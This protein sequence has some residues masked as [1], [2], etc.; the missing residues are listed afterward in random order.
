MSEPEKIAINGA[1]YRLS[2]LSEEARR[3]FEM[4]RV[5]DGKLAELQRDVTIHQAARTAYVEALLKTLPAKP[6][7]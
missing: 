7:P 3:N 1:E 2:D 6:V 5:I 4:V